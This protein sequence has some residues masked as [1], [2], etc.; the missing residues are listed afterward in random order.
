MKIQG[1]TFLVTGGSSGLGAACVQ[2]LVSAGANV[3]IADLNREAGEALVNELGENVRFARTDVTSEAD[4]QGA[5]ETAVSRYLTYSL[6]SSSSSV[7]FWKNSTQGFILS[8]EMWKLP[9]KSC[10]FLTAS[11]LSSSSS[12]TSRKCTSLL[13]PSRLARSR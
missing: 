7:G 8:S 12:G 11:R 9:C 13:A 5:V 4:V 6:R 1:S 3:V 10:E 2:R